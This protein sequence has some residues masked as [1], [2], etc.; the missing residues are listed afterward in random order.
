MQKW[1]QKHIKDLNEKGI[2]FVPNVLSQNKCKYYIDRFEKLIKKFEKKRIPLNSSCQVIENPF[3]HDFK[4]IDLIYHKKIDEILKNKIEKNYVLINANIIN[5]IYRFFKIQK[6]ERLGKT[7]HHDSRL[8]GNKRLE[9]GFSYI[10][11]TMFNDFSDDNA[12]TLYVDKS[13]N[14]RDKPKRRFNYY[15]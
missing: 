13:H 6:K 9:K 5:R 4:L 7:W 1:V 14:R 11:I 15:A 8:V 2:T 3:R 10:A 12:S